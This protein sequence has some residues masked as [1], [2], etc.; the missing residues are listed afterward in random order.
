MPEFQCAKCVEAVVKS[1][2]AVRA[3]CKSAHLGYQFESNK[4][5]GRDEKGIDAGTGC[6]KWPGGF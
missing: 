4:I 5:H 3:V 1:G 6:W 2:G